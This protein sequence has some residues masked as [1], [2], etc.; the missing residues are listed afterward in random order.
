MKSFSVASGKGGVGKTSFVINLAL[1][2]EELNQRVLIFDADLGLANVDIML[3]LSPKFDIRYVLNGQLNLKDIILKTEY[4][5]SII[6]AGS[7]VTELTQLNTSQKL[8][9]RAQME[10]AFQPFDYLFFDIS[11]GI[12]EN[13]LFFTQLA[14]ER[15]VLVT[16]EPTSMA[17]AYAY[18]KVAYRKARVKEFNIVVNMAKDES[19]GKKIYQQLLYVSEKFLPEIKL[20]LLGALPYD[21][22]VKRAIKAQIPFVKYCPDAKISVRMREVAYKLLN[23]RSSKRERELE[24]FLE[25]FSNL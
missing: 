13:V 14:E 6:P 4:G 8:L 1:I 21:E 10:E 12:S 16:P 18:L 24:M 17:D 9:L 19:E 5:F 15:I 22:C 23:R 2:L 25:R 3:G 7:G 11:A 20:S